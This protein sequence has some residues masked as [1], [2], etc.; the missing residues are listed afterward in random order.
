MVAGFFVLW[1]LGL[2][3]WGIVGVIASVAL[4]AV[5]RKRRRRWQ[6]HRRTV[7][8]DARGAAL[9]AAANG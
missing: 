2:V 8:I 3:L 7:S 1:L 6:R 5:Y 4:A 9:I